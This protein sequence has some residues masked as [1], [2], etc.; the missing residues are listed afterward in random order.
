MPNQ[1][2]RPGSTGPSHIR[3]LNNITTEVLRTWS[4]RETNYVHQGW[5]LS[6][7]A[8]HNQISHNNALSVTKRVIA[9][10]LRVDIQLQQLKPNPEFEANIRAALGKPNNFEKFHGL[11]RVFELW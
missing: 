3:E 5:S 11:Y 9:Q 1:V 4:E 8:S 10:L 6:R 2:A 7:I